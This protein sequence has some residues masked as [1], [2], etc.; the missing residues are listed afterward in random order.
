MCFRACTFKMT[1]TFP[2]G[3]WVKHLRLSIY[4]MSSYHLCIS[5]AYPY[6]IIWKIGPSIQASQNWIIIWRNR[7]I[8]PSF[9]WMVW[10]FRLLPGTLSVWFIRIFTVIKHIPYIY[11]YIVTSQNP[12]CISPMLATSG[13]YWSSSGMLQ[14]ADYLLV[15]MCGF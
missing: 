9:G 12:V 11:I 14:S 15:L 13:R 3:Q 8:H 2:R 7:T 6:F 1:T 5:L 4:E 10:F